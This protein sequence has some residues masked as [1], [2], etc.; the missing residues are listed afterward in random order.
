MV[1]LSRHHLP[2]ACRRYRVLPYLWWVG[3]DVY[4]QV[5]GFRDLGANVHSVL[6]GGLRHGLAG[7]GED[8]SAPRSGIQRFDYRVDI[9]WILGLTLPSPFW[10][11]AIRRQS[12]YQMDPRVVVPLK[13]DLG[14]GLPSVSGVWPHVGGGLN[15]GLLDL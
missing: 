7:H 14:L 6:D 4:A 12:R 8:H 1:C 15:R 9:R 10:Y 13:C 11:P 2:S 5:E 3:G